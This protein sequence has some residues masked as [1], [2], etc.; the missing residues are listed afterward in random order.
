MLFLMV[1]VNFAVLEKQENKLLSS[2]I[3]EMLNLYG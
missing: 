3:P 1:F 2:D